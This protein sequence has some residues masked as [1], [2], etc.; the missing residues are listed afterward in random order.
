MPT[1]DDTEKRP[2]T[3]SQKPKALAGSMP[4]ASTAFRLVLRREGRRGRRGRVGW[5]RV[6]A[7][8]PR[9]GRH[10]GRLLLRQHPPD[11]HHVLGHRRSAQS[12]RQPGAGGAGVEHRLG[13]GERLAAVGGGQRWEGCHQPGSKGG[14]GTLPKRPRKEDPPS[15]LPS[16][17]AS[18][19]KQRPPK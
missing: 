4:N 6:T 16:S 12:L 8:G 10:P 11:S 9:A 17:C 3:Q 18:R 2:P 1:A 15:S 13:G 19:R 14:D 7:D 5:G